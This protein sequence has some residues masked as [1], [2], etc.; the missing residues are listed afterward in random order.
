MGTPELQA[1]PVKLTCEVGNSGPPGVGVQGGRGACLFQ[2]GSVPET[3]S[4][5]AKA[6]SHNIYFFHITLPAC[7]SGDRI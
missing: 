7:K 3:G 4:L 6:C 2:T 1:C 5:L